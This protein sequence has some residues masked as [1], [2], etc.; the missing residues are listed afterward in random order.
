MLMT[1]AL[2]K[3]SVEDCSDY[4][5]SNASQIMLISLPTTHRP[6][7]AWTELLLVGNEAIDADHRHLFE[8]VQRLH[9]GI[10]QKHG[11]SLI[12]DVL[13]ELMEYAREHFAREEALMAEIRFPGKEEHAFEHRLLTHRLRNLHLQFESGQCKLSDALEIFLDRWLAR[14]ILTSDL[15]FAQSVNSLAVVRSAKRA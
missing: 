15:H 7:I 8:V 9:D 1:H 14:H 10:R 3:A 6:I 5:C 12:R 13:D 11:A 2:M 4:H